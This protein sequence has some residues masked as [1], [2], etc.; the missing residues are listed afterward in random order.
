MLE[1]TGT[2]ADKLKEQMKE[3]AQKRVRINLVLEAI[4][5]AENIEVTE[6]EVTAEVEKMAEMYGMPVDA[7]KQALGS[8]DALA[9]DLKVRKAVDFLV[10]N[11]A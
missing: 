3:D 9:E 10:E 4:I 11:A 6:E 2:D 1:F 8:V 7:I 5:E